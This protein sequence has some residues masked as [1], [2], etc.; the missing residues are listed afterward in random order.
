MLQFCEN[1]LF[2]TINLLLLLN[3]FP[4]TRHTRMLLNQGIAK[5][6]LLLLEGMLCP[7]RANSL[8]R[9]QQW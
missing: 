2:T 7:S 6:L 5:D 9:L 1:W 3:V 4:D 8:D